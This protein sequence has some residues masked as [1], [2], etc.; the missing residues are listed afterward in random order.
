MN[1]SKYIVISRKLFINVVIRKHEF[2]IHK[3]Q[4]HALHTINIAIKLLE[5]GS[6][7]VFTI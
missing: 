2:V 1:S 4:A 3:L 6:V 5:R 7:I